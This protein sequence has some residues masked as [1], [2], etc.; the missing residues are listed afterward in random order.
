MKQLSA[1]TKNQE[2]F[3]IKGIYKSLKK[4]AFTYI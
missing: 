2:N 1:K 4:K 3:K